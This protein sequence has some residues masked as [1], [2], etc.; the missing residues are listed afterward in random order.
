M[1]GFNNPVRGDLG[2]KEII[3]L[4]SLERH[5]E[6]G[7][8]RQTWRAPAAPG[9]RAASTHIYFL[10]AV[11]EVSQWHRI[12]AEEIWHWYGGAPLVLTS[13]TPEG[14]SPKAV[15]LGPDL[16]AGHLF[17]HVVEA[18]HWQAAE[19]LGAWSLMGCTVAPGFDFAGFELAPPHWRPQID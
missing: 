5:P 18:H 13:A 6:G 16:R 10:L 4:L 8:F 3:R 9:E 1:D 19:P 2:A 12:D 15:T 14:R 7:W 17:H 11:D